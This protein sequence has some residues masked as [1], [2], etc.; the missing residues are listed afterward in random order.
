[1]DSDGPAEVDA[2]LMS[3]TYRQTVL[4]QL[5]TEGPAT[6]NELAAVTNEPRPHIS[7]ALR[8]LK[9]RSIVELRVEESRQ[10]GRYY[11]LT[12]DGDAAWD[13]L[14]D[15]IRH[16]PWAVEAPDDPKSTRIVD[17]AQAGLG[18]ALRSV[19]S[20]D[21][22]RVRFLYAADGILEQYTDEEIDRAIQTFVFDHQL[23]SACMPNE[24]VQSEAV[25][26]SEFTLVRVG[27]KDRCR[28]AITFDNDADVEI[29]RFTRALSSIFE[30][31]DEE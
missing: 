21:G 13:R 27:E 26:F 19:V 25:S 9:E 3:S 8:E 29:P 17:T 5:G 4:E 16:V 10:V 31:A 20:Y 7:R 24:T 11:G 30:A 15:E 1:M 2:Y 6:P 28:F 22:E 23:E 14:R 18:K 12:A